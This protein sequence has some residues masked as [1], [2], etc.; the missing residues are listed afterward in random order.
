MKVTPKE[1]K[2]RLAFSLEEKE[3]FTKDVIQQWY[4]YWGGRCT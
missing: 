1:L 4:E 2:C 3:E